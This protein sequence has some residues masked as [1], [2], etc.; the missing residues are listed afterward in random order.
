MPAKLPRRASHHLGEI[1]A[2]KRRHRILAAAGA[3]ED[4]ATLVDT[5]TD[6]SALA[7]NSNLALDDVVERLEL[8]VAEGPV[9]DRRSLRQPRC[10][11]PSRRLANH[12]EVPG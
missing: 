3:L 9:F 6:V 7:G 2:A 11:V 8:F 1:G 12:L 4:I 10:S 5:A